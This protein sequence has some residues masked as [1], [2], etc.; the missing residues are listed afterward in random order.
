MSP[1]SIQN[2]EHALKQAETALQNALERESNLETKHVRDISE[3]IHDIKNPLTAMMGY[4]SLMQSEF[5]G[6]L[7]H[8]KYNDCIDVIDRSSQR[9]LKICESLLK[10]HHTDRTVPTPGNDND[11]GLEDVD[12]SAILGEIVEL[13][14]QMAEER[15]INLD[16]KIVKDFPTIRANPE[17]IYRMMTNL[18]SN[19]MKFT[20]RNGRVTVEA[21]TT[22]TG[23]GL[24]MIVRD[25]GIGMSY[26]QIREILSKKR[27]TSTV[28]PHGDEGTGLGLDI[29]NR[30]VRG[31][32]GKMDI[33]STENKGTRIKLQFPG[34]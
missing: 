20:P 31:L 13:F 34:P 15:G 11:D 27:T 23:D 6:P 16:T 30:M 19:A 4:I 17:H 2:A 8:A 21:E 12:A 1:D 32:H 25:S 28:S 24:V 29:V 3:I 9:L 22:E 33:I 5:A 7:G 26:D 14:S 10:T 18:V